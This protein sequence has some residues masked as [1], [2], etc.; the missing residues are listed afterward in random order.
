MRLVSLI[1]ALRVVLVTIAIALAFASLGLLTHHYLDAA[2]HAVAENL[3]LKDQL[4]G[5]IER[6]AEVEATLGTVAA[7]RR[8]IDHVTLSEFSG[9]LDHAGIVPGDEARI[10]TAA[11]S[12]RTQEVGPPQTRPQQ[13]LLDRLADSRYRAG[14]LA[15]EL[16]G[17]AEVLTQRQDIL[18]AMPSIL[19]TKGWISSD[20]GVRESPFHKGTEKQH[21]GMDVAAAEGMPVIATADGIVAYAGNNGSYGKYVKI[22]HGY[23]ITTRYGHAAELLVKRGQ[24]VKRGDKIAT[25]GI[26]GRTT[27]AHVHYEVWVHEVA[28]D[29]R[30]F[31]FGAKPD[32]YA[33]EPVGP[34]AA[35]GAP[36]GG[37]IELAGVVLAPAQTADATE[38]LVDFPK[39]LGIAWDSPVFTLERGLF[40]AAAPD[41]IRGATTSDLAVFTALLITF[42][43]ACAAMRNPGGAGPGLLTKPLSRL[44]GAREH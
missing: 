36:M 16:K 8:S 17:T 25:I 23:G 13:S 21:N 33:A 35:A 6:I 9:V 30:R 38:V 29:P 12:V 37:E 3:A 27:G 4:R 24:H 19:P 39:D 7:E 22:D 41:Q 28:T 32:D 42:A 20:F 40:A 26:T 15:S 18:Q 43:V 5:L 1:A 44:L 31:L 14:E 10:Y 2:R 11:Q 34:I